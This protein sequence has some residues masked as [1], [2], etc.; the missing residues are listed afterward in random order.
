MHGIM[1]GCRLCPRN[2][3]ADRT[4]GAGA[5]GAPDKL[6]VNL[7]QLHRWEEPVISG[8]C[9]S[10]T[11][12]FSH[13]AMKCVF[14]Q[15]WRISHMGHGK[16]CTEQD[17]SDM[18][19]E[20]QGQ[21][22]H[23]INIVTG[24]HYTPQIILSLEI[25]RRNGLSIPVVWNSSAYENVD[26]LRA[27]EG[28][29]DVY[30]PDLKYSSPANSA[31]YSGAPEYPEKARRAILEMARQVGRLRVED[32]LAE[33]GILIRI[34][35]LPGDLNSTE[36]SLRW[37]SDNLGD[38]AWIS[39]MGQYYPAHRAGEFPEI[40]RPLSEAEYCAASELLDKYG[41]ENGFVQVPGSS[42]D[43]TPDFKV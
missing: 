11:I 29:V 39:L 7:H 25:A 30:L 23:N 18:M 36:D 9:G 14:C 4:A 6:K 21:G 5:C 10:G 33:K 1:R 17:L 20:L 8:T 28:M 2:C 32:G 13:C 27:L 38:G 40:S 41:L 31:R 16:I 19:L 42:C 35:V 34:L 15:N 3:G 43:Y 24:T 12:F 37:I 22:A 26:T